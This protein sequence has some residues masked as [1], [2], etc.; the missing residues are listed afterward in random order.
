MLLTYS[1]NEYVSV[2]INSNSLLC[3]MLSP[4]VQIVSIGWFI[5]RL[6]YKKDI[7]AKAASS[8]LCIILNTMATGM[9]NLSTPS[10]VAGSC[11]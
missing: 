5:W 7:A 4:L 6:F 1:V 2:L 11:Q 3:S 10:G 9:H 8:L